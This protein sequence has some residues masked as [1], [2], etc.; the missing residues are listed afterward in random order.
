LNRPAP[1]GAAAPF[2]SFTDSLGDV[3]VAKGGVYGG[4]WRRAKDGL[5]CRVYRNSNYAVTAGANT[6][7]FNVASWDPYSIYNGI[8]F[9]FVFPLAG[10]YLLVG[11]IAQ[12]VGTGQWFQ[13]NANITGSITG[14]TYLGGCPPTAAGPADVIASMSDI[15]LVNAAGAYFI[16]STN[17]SSTQIDGNASGGYTVASV[18]YLHP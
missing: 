16:L 2:T 5:Y 9:S 8:N 12:N 13:I 4:A 14:S 10:Y 7:Q 17:G 1:L 15:Y 11:N 6:V 18:T 3:W